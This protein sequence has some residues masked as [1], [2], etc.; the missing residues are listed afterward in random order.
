MTI[1]ICLPVYNEELILKKNINKI[2]NY[3]DSLENNFDWHIYIVVNGSNDDSVNIS[4]DLSKK[5]KRVSS[6]E[7]NQAGKG[8][9][10]KDCWQKSNADFFIYMDI[11]LAV[12]LNFLPFLIDKLNEGYDLVWGSRRLPSSKVN[13]GILRSFSSV[14]YN[15]F[16]KVMLNHNYSDLQCGFKGVNNKIKNNVLD[17]IED[18]N[19]FFDTELI[20]WSKRMDYN[21]KEIPINWQEDRYQERKSKIKVFKDAKFFIYKTIKLRKKLKIYKILGK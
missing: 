12:S 17:K 4:K 6:Y 8:R 21:L 14:I 19:W 20:I 9:A 13:R 18:N 16:S 1:D 5:D 2:I 11:D 15:I 7:L 10:I 3:L